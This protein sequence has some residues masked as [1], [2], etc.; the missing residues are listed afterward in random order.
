MI[1]QGK[2]PSLTN[3]GN[4]QKKEKCGHESKK[5]Q[6]SKCRGEHSLMMFK[7]P[8][9][10]MSFMRILLQFYRSR[11]FDENRTSKTNAICAR[12]GFQIFAVIGCNF[13]HVADKFNEV[14]SMFAATNPTRTALK[15]LERDTNGPFAANGH[16]VQKIPY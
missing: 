12:F 7:G 10:M 2:K 4:L 5:M 8:Y 9:K 16:V 15:S 1:V 14:S 11:T 6:L 3:T 13:L